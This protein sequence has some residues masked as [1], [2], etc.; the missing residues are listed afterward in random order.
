MITPYDRGAIGEIEKAIQTSDLGLNP[1]NDGKLIR[2]PIP[3][4][5]EERRRAPIRTKRPKTKNSPS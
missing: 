1:M 4:L 2:I 3:E 5:N